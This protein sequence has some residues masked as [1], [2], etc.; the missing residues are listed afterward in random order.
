MEQR[1]EHRV[2][3]DG[4]RAAEEVQEGQEEDAGGEPGGG[5]EGTHWLPRG[6]LEPASYRYKTAPAMVAQL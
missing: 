5:A 2:P 6:H 3:G 1:G 4:G